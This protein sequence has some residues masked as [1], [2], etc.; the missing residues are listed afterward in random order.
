[1]T[2]TEAWACNPNSLEAEAGGLSWVWS[3]HGLHSKFQAS[4]ATGWHPVSKTK[5]KKKLKMNK[6]IKYIL[7]QTT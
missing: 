2:S 1:M 7:I 4:L 6:K 5:K 3:Q